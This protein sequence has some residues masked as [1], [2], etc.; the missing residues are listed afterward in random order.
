MPREAGREA[1][2]AQGRE[3]ARKAKFA[4]KLFFCAAILNPVI[5]KVLKS[6][7]NFFNYFSPRILNLNFFLTADLKRGEGG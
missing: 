3:V 2:F 5:G 4:E 7:T 1:K 6:E